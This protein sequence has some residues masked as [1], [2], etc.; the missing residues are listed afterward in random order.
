M[1]KIL[2]NYTENL[3]CDIQEPQK[4]VTV[5]TDAPKKIQGLEES[6]S[7]TELFRASLGSCM[8]TMIAFVARDKNI[9]LAGLKVEVEEFEDEKLRLEINIYYPIK[10][11]EK[12][13]TILERSAKSCPVHKRLHP[14][15]E[16]NVHFHYPNE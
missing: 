4:G 2:V 5:R 13:A 11:D 1:S 16:C 9:D 7:P 3:R 8:T 6:F 14:D 10:L 12:L 15:I